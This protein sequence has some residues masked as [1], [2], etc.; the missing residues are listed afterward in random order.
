MSS[1]QV[2]VRPRGR[3]LR[4]AAT[5]EARNAAIDAD[6]TLLRPTP[7]ASG[8][9]VA[10]VEELAAAERQA[11]ED[12]ARVG[13]EDGF[14]AGRRDAQAQA[15]AETQRSADAIRSA[16][17]TLATASVALQAQQEVAIA[18]VE[19]QIVD[20]AVAI[21]EAVIGRELSTVD[22]P[23]RD[24]LVRALAL[25]PRGVNAVARCHPSDAA[26]LDELPDAIA[27]R[28]VTVVADPAVEPGGCIVEIGACRIDAQIGPALDRV[29]EALQG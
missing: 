11:R 9:L 25:A 21:A 16:L 18:D 29:R 10:T 7:E 17:A 28:T 1:D 5:G 19:R 22:A 23:A 20:V 4:G 26:T 6:L 27:D 14:T 3:V 24:A 12:A 13:Y 2:L 15:H 8:S